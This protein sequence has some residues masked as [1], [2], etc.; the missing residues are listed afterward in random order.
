MKKFVLIALIA[1]VM[2]IGSVAA[3][4]Y[5]QNLSNPKTTYVSS[6]LVE[7]TPEDIVKQS[8]GIVLGKVEKTQAIKIPS[9]IR[10][11]KEDIVTIATVKVEKYLANP[12]NLSA[13]YIDVQTLGG[14]VG[15]ETMV[16]EDSP[17]FVQGERVVVF[18]N[19]MDSSSNA[20]AVYAGIQ[21]KFTVQADNGVGN[22]EERMY[23]RKVFGKDMTLKEFENKIFSISGSLSN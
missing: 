5:Y 21:G 20:F 14:T 13:P 17:T 23:F 4:N 9:K 11:N 7:I 1:I 2:G 10:A 15:N 19:E 12:K 16:A 18:L 6:V 3:F 22:D 8:S